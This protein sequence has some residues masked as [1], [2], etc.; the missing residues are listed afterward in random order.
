MGQTVRERERGLS[1][2]CA[3]WWWLLWPPFQDSRLMS[4]WVSHVWMIKVEDTIKLEDQ[5]EGMLRHGGDGEAEVVVAAGLHGRVKME[6]QEEGEA[7]PPVAAI[8]EEQ[9]GDERV[10]RV[11]EEEETGGERRRSTRKRRRVGEE[12]GK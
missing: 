12:E 5:V 10:V 4:S 7:W 11:K 6:D 2:A 8:V 3:W 1:F 9:A